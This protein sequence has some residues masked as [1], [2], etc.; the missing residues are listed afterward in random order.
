[1]GAFAH[2]QCPYNC[3]E[4]YM[5]TVYS[6]RNYS[7]VGSRQVKN[8]CLRLP[9]VLVKVSLTLVRRYENDGK[10]VIAGI[11]A[12]LK[13]H[14]RLNQLGGESLASMAR[15]RTG[16]RAE[17]LIHHVEEE[18]EICKVVFR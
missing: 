9:E 14:V 1:M 6:C 15:T 11:R 2:K 12:N 3:F 8:T 5:G 13:G 7:T 16:I 18:R 4:N 10:S 17:N